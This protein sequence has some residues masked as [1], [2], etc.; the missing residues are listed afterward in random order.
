MSHF[1]AK[2]RETRRDLLTDT[3]MFLGR[4]TSKSKQTT[5]MKKKKTIYRNMNFAIYESADREIC[6]NDPLPSLSGV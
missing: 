3:S 4:S 1:A 5:K 2:Y 6:S